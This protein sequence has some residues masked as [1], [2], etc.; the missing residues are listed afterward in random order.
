MTYEIIDTER[1][2]GRIAWTAENEDGGQISGVLTRR[3]PGNA[4]LT[5]EAL[6]QM[7]EK[8]IGVPV[9]DETEAGGLMKADSFTTDE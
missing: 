7:A 4:V 3:A 1:M 5:D 6:D 2:D 9:R 8:L